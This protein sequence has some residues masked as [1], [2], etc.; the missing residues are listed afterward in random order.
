MGKLFSYV[1][2]WDDGAAPN[3]FWDV[4]TLVICKPK[5]R[6]AANVD[7]WI[8]G[9]GGKNSPMG[10]TRGQVVYAMRVTKKV[11]M[12]DY[13][14]L[15]SVELPNKIPVW[16]SSE[17]TQRFGDCVYD[18]T[19]EPPNIRRS[20][21]DETNRGT[22][23][24]GKYA[25]LSTEF[26]YFG[27]GAPSLPEAL[28]PIVKDGRHH[29]WKPNEPYKSA[30]VEWIRTQA[31]GVNGDPQ[32]WGDREIGSCGGCRMSEGLEELAVRDPDC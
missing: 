20:C 12:R 4:C 11:T 21:H 32:M 10:D 30:F 5:V 3:P 23:L 22:D 1:V 6:L 18:F 31:P 9:T 24:G 27:K 16:T 28:L 17:L 15:C 29:Q 13:D 8:L 2:R 19:I 7:D 26:Y 14:R 25:L